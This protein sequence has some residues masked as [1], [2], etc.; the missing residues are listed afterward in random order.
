MTGRSCHPRDMTSPRIDSAAPLSRLRITGIPWK[1][2]PGCCLADV[3]RDAA[4]RVRV[5]PVLTLSTRSIVIRSPSTTYMTQYLPTRSRSM[6]P[7]RKDSAGYGFPARASNA[8]TTARMPPVSSRNREAVVVA[9]GDHSTLTRLHRAAASPPRWITSWGPVPAGPA[10]CA[11]MPA[12][13]PAQADNPTL[14]CHARQRTQSRAVAHAR[15]AS[16]IPAIRQR[17]HPP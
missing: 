11:V 6:S 8:A 7:H 1:V 5:Q 17:L 13:V 10:G 2:T 9:L 16:S 12:T 15:P 3:T 4:V 14:I